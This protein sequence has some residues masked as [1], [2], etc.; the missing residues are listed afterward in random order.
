M[1]YIL[2]FHHCLGQIV[3]TKGQPDGQ[4]SNFVATLKRTPDHSA[5]YWSYLLFT[6]IYHCFYE[7]SQN[8]QNFH[9]KPF[10][11]DKIPKFH[12]DLWGISA[13]VN[14]FLG[15]FTTH[16]FTN[17]NLNLVRL[18]PDESICCKADS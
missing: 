17:S 15:L 12:Q 18:L 13:N 9:I 4:N 16:F 14:Y 7:S 2:G 6:A 10:F 11:F 1:K 5:L 8:F 3:R